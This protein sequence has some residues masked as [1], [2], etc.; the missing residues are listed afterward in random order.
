MKLAAK[1]KVLSGSLSATQDAY[2]DVGRVIVRTSEI[3]VAIWDGA[4]GAGKGGTSDVIEMA[5]ASGK[6]VVWIDAAGNI[7]PRL[8]EPDLTG[9]EPPLQD[10]K[11]HA[12]RLTRDDCARLV[13]CPP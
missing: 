7:P 1:I 10:R 4:P 8:L 3:V 12:L 11:V 13:T 2:A 6:P 9:R 5:L